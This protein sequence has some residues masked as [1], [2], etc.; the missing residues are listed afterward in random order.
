MLIKASSASTAG[1]ALVWWRFRCCWAY[2]YAG[3]VRSLSP[4]PL[5]RCRRQAPVASSVKVLLRQR[6]R[7]RTSSCRRGLA[8]CRFRC[9]DKR[10]AVAVQARDRHE[11]RKLPFRSSGGG[12][13]L[14][15]VNYLSIAGA[16][17]SLSYKL[18]A[19]D[20][21]RSGRLV[22]PFGPELPLTDRAYHFVWLKGLEARPSA[23]P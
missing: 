10:T 7:S 15:A 3:I 2:S 11:C 8:S 6:A 14:N 23:R 4:S 22:T 13:R 19:S 21:V 20:D 16:G 18:I 12:C 9:T 1:S 5:A 17:V